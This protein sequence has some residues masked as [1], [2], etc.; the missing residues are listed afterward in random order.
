LKLL[1]GVLTCVASL[2]ES[3]RPAGEAQ[4][5]HLLV[6][7]A[8]LAVG[9]A[10][11]LWDL[12]GPGLHGDEETM[13]MPTMHIVEHGTPLLPSGMFYPRAVVQLYLMAGSVVLFGE[14]EWAMR[15]PSVLCGVLL[16]WLGW[17]LG[18]RF[19]APAWNLAFA[20][21][22]ALLPALIE[23]AQTARMYVFLMAC[24]AGYAI[25][26]FEW[27][28]T[29]RLRYLVAAVL[30]LLLG[31]QFH[32]LAIF[33]AFLTLFPGLLQGDLRRLGWGLA[34][35]VALAGGFLAID[36]W[37]GSSYWET[38]QMEGIREVLNGPR[39]SSAIPQLPLW[40]LACAGAV[41]VAVGAFVSR[42][43]AAPRVRLVATALFS[44]GLLAQLLFANH[45]ALLLYVAALVVATRQ[46][47]VSLPRLAGL[48]VLGAVLAAVQLALLRANG[49]ESIRQMLGAMAGK[50]SVWPLFAVAQYS[51]IA[52][53]LAAAATVFALWKIANRQRVPDFMLFFVLGVW[54]PLTVIGL[55]MWDIPPRYAG[56]QVMPL[57]LSGVAGAQWLFT[58]LLERRE[59]PRRWAAAGAAAAGLLVVNPIAFGQEVVAGERGLPDHKG[60]AEFIK[61]LQLLPGDVLV[62]EDVLQQTYYLGHVDYWLLNRQVAHPFIYEAR[63]ELRDFYTSTRLIGTGAELEALIER[64][65]RGAIYVIGSGENHEDGRRHM[66]GD[67]IYEVLASPRFELVFTGRDG[68]THVWK[69]AAPDQ[70]T[71][72]RVA[73]MEQ[74]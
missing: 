59:A 65:D 29:E 39:A 23:E 32:T 56:A 50:P 35:F 49:V 4:R 9:T 8:I 16:I 43:I 17:R 30:V 55:F 54:L 25:L 51:L 42:P 60:A 41:A 64:P 15:L 2:F 13:A 37:I 73:G 7:V 18:Q 27:E 57:L 5:L 53:L 62:A 61:S 72:S 10:V 1:R 31:L 11:R 33:A 48:A 63:G 34:A 21:S 71:R 44:A 69:L 36:A 24:V 20:A 66:R 40:M 14:S 12:G 70:A 74:H 22:I 26:L 45:A 68:L 47:G 3:A 58:G 6:L 28:R 52:A 19:L 67:G 46:N 38:A